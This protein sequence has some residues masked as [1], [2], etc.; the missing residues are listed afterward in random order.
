MQQVAAGPSEPA[1]V[2]ITPE[3]TESSDAE[4]AV[5]AST[6]KNYAVVDTAVAAVVNITVTA[7]VNSAERVATVI[8]SAVA[9]IVSTT[10]AAVVAGKHMLKP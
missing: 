7:V 3:V 4:A 9:V 8:D 6:L 1:A 5:D 2:K 10:E